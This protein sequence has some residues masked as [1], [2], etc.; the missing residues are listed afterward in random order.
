MGTKK[1]D[2]DWL[3]TGFMILLLVA[4]VG[5]CFIAE[6]VIVEKLKYSKPSTAAGFG[7]MYGALGACF[8]GLA[9]A[10]VIWAI[11]LQ[12]KDLKL[13]RE[14]LELTRA[15]LR[16]TTKANEDSAEALEEQVK[17]MKVYTLALLLPEVLRTRLNNT[18]DTVTSIIVSS[19]DLAC[20]VVDDADSYNKTEKI[21]RA[22]ESISDELLG[23]LG[24][25]EKWKK[26][27]EEENASGGS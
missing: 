11:L 27:S 7:D 20:G 17:T 6:Y 25:A 9:F 15:E 1:G 12:R 23:E 22:M 26:G 13:T 8:S 19:L 16:A 5:V 24:I 21:F 14:D 4:I 3:L 10:G 2:R 18:H